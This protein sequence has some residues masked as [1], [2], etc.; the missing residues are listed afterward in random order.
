M[1]TAPTLIPTLRTFI[2]TIRTLIPTVRTLMPTAFTETQRR[3]PDDEH[4]IE[5]TQSAMSC[6]ELRARDFSDKM[7]I[8]V[9]EVFNEMK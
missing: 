2:P 9:C 6:Q 7:V 1:P 5:S 8:A 4:T 3:I